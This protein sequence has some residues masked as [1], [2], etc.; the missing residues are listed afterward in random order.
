MMFK[1]Q[2]REVMPMILGLSPSSGDTR[3]IKLA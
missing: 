1:G 2:T 3:S